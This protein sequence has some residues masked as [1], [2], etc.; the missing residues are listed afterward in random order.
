VQATAL[1]LAEE[2]AAHPPSGVQA[3]KRLIHE[4]AGLPLR[5]RFDRE[6]AVQA[7]YLGANDLSDLFQPSGN[8]R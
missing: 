3:V 1:A 7:A 2:I 6:A 8:G 4:S 5:E